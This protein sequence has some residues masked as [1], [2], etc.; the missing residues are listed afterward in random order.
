MRFLDRSA[1][2][3]L[4]AEGDW[5]KNDVDVRAHGYHQSIV[6][7]VRCCEIFR[8][9][10]IDLQSHARVTIDGLC[11]FVE[12][13]KMKTPFSFTPRPTHTQNINARGRFYAG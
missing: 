6:H 12:R 4:T 3:L 9:K 1:I 10:I 11:R 5:E 2:A 7:G 8:T 13:V